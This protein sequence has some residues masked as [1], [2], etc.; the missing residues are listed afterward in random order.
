MTVRSLLLGIICI[1]AV[2]LQAQNVTFGNLTTEDGLSQFSVNSLY[3][4]EN[5]MLWIGTR[6]GLN[7]YNGTDI[8]TYKLEKDNP[9][10]LFSN[11]VTRITGDQNGHIYLLCNDG[12]A[13]LDLRTLQFKTLLVDHIQ[14]IYYHDGL[15]IAKKNEIYLYNEKTGNFD[16]CYQL[17]GK[18]PE[19]YC[20][21]SDGRYLWIGTTSEGV[22]RLK[23]DNQE[24]THPIETGNITSIYED[25]EKELWIGSWE[26]GLYR[27][28]TDGTIV[29]FRHDANNPH[30]ISSN[31]ARACCEDNLGNIWI[32]TFNGL[33]RYD[34]SNGLFQNHTTNDAKGDGLT[35]SS[36]W[37]I[38]KDRQGTLWLGTYFG[39]VNYF[40]PEYNIYTAYHYSSV[41]KKGLSNPVVGRIVEDKDGNLWIATEGGG[42]NFLDRRKNKFRWYRTDKNNPNSIAHD[43]VKALYYDKEHQ[44]IWIG[45]HMGGLDRLNLKNFH[46][47]HHRMEEGNPNS[48]PSNIIR[49]LEP[50]G[51]DSLIVATQNGV[52]MI[53]KASGKCRRLFQ[54]TKE[55]RSIKMVADIE[56]DKNGDL[57][58]AA[59]GEGVFRYSFQTHRLKSYRHQ[60]DVANTLSNNNV[61]SILCD[62]Q[63]RLWFSTSGSGLDL[64]HPQS[65]SF[66]NFDQ[67]HNGLVSDC[68]YEAQESPVSGNLLLI[69]N[70]GFSI[71]NR[72]TH[73]AKNYNRSNGFPF[74][75]INENALCVTSDGEI[76]LGSTQ[77]MI[78]FHEMELNLP[79]KPYNIVL[80]KL[81]V[82]GKEIET[83]DE[84]GI[85]PQSLCYTPEITLKA[86]Q[87][88]FTIEFAT[89]NY[90]PANKDRIIYQLKG[91]SDKWTDALN[92][93]ITY[94][95]LNAGTYTL[96]IKPQTQ[97]A[98]I[99][100]PVRL[101][102]H[103]LPPF[104]KTIWAY[105]FYILAI[106]SLSWYLIR[107]YK[108]RIKL[109]ESLK[110][111]KKHAQDIELL[112]QSKLRF[113]TNISHEF[114]TPLTIII[115]QIE[116]LLQ[117]QN[118]TPALYNKV[119]SMYKNSIQLRELI[120]ELLDFRKQEQGHMKIKVS[121]HNLID[122]LYENYL[123]FLEYAHTRQVN[124]IFQKGTD[125][126]EV[127]YDQKQM[128]KVVNNLLSNA[129]K[130]TR[131]ADT[132]TLSVDNEN[133]NAVIRVSDTGEGMDA[134]ELDKIF[135]RF[136]QVDSISSDDTRQSTGTGIGLALTKGIVELH[137]GTIRVESTLGKGTCFIVTLPLGNSQFKEEEIDRRDHVIQQIDIDKP[138]M[139]ILLKSEMD[140]DQ[141]SKPQSGSNKMLVVEDNESIRQMLAEI[142]APFYQVTT[143]ADGE[144][145]WE[146]IGKEQPNIVVSDVVMP[147]MSGT[148]LCKRIKSDFNTCHI[149]VVLLTARTAI[150]QNI[151]GLRIGADDYITKPFNT[152]LLISRCN[153]L[154]NSR[155]LLQEKFSKQPQTTVQ[156]LATN[157][158]DKDILDR[159]MAVIEKH[160][161]DA[162]FNVNTF[163][164]EM[165]MAR[166]NLFTKLKG[167]TGQTPNEFILTI[168]LKKGAYLLRNNPE[169]NITE[170]SDRIGFSS[171]RYFAKCF[172]D[173]YHIS[174]LAYRKE[175]DA[176]N[177]TEGESEKEDET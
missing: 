47:T 43:N 108:M 176:G 33:N 80:S 14:S 122:F 5:G 24:L 6:E 68:I 65:D 74:S 51:K 128:Q 75:T 141:P 83:G 129:L 105:L 100:P 138:E 152:S 99:C 52:C 35:H 170:I 106:G 160:L 92:S 4:D 147:R 72:H 15:Y 82:N 50:Y 20:L 148:E 161:D 88:M 53:D 159:A 150:E 27:V 18:N 60:H 102:I 10:S 1:F 158:I 94:T 127:W 177:D 57:W 77:G 3:I 143:A 111:E 154:V 118:F 9:Y 151:E 70:Q 175:T 13:Q 81:Y 26:D 131:P 98:E 21:H 66:E 87:S 155:I 79:P 115:S 49:D 11:T 172:K 95:N 126:L 39:G 7:R 156:Q 123:L 145:A 112:N 29:N 41:E 32:G 28:K 142:F 140:A 34:K 17:P 23:M 109:R 89:S 63:G 19:I 137:H 73:Q 16:L 139:D 101:T 37:C 107:T 164:R 113:F 86:D 59:T 48:L 134:K 40:N 157:P 104:Y 56:F 174:P 163:A 96:V 12:V 173:V 171:P 135:E 130:H 54:D 166:T 45:T 78:S 69:T 90:V 114:R 117:V 103:I 91:F 55:G 84:S 136:Y 8:Q 71:F 97:P 165:A 64:Y 36:I 38:V 125:S 31:F 58:I 146:Q 42:L 116:T 132:I 76:F 168:R 124:L 22:Y 169:L 144:E 62:K 93:A 162:D 46:F 133:G 2:Q 61:Y 121:R 85:L 120:N 119:L 67:A 25:S 149:P 153:N 167:I 44:E 30:S 110:Y